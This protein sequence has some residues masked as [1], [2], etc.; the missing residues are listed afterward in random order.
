MNASFAQIRCSRQALRPLLLAASLALLGACA[1][2]PPP[3][4]ELTAA[5]QAVS[6]AN[7]ADADQYAPDVLATAR[8]ELTQAQ[9]A[10]A[11]GRQGDARAMAIAA[12]AAGDLAYAQSH[13]ETLRQDYQQRRGEIA[14]LRRQLQVGT[15]A[16]TDADVA[17]ADIAME[18]GDPA[19]RLQALD[20][21]PRLNGLAA[22]QRLQARQAVEAL[23]T[24]RSSQRAGATV[25]ASR[26]VSIAEL[27]AR[28]EL[29]ERAIDR[30][31]RTRSEL[32]VEA[33]R[34]EAER[35]RQEAERLRVQAQIQAEE[36]QRLRAAAEAEA[37]ARQQADD[38]IIDVGGEQAAKLKAARKREA[39]LARQE[40]ELMAAQKAAEAGKDDDSGD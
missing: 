39:E 6:R 15:E 31:D 37:A 25:L 27:A 29:T 17:A 22:Y 32:L 36:T 8:S 19:M 34:R 21:D 11:K 13:A 26:R 30:L 9:A 20:A 4:T 40:A 33:S 12:A 7:D 3:T 5:Q 2:L 14:N 23:A 35:A 1:T 10:M 38:V 28:S 16:Q 24:V 18:A